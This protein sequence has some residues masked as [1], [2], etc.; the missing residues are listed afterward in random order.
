MS[1]LR[2]GY[3]DRAVSMRREERETLKGEQIDR[4]VREM[5]EV[6]ALRFEGTVRGALREAWEQG[7]KA[8]LADERGSDA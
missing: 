1:A 4:I 8:A 2:G 3:E 7:E 5:D 6:D